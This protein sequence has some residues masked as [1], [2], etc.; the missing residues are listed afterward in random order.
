MP[1]L[2]LTPYRPSG[3]V[4]AMETPFSPAADR[5]KEAI[6]SVLKEHLPTGPCLG[7]EVGSATG[8]HGLY[9]LEH[10]SEL[11][12]VF[13]DQPQW[14]DHLCSVSDHPRAIGPYVYT[15][16]TDPLPRVYP[17]SDSHSSQALA[18]NFL[19]TS[20][21][22]H[23]MSWEEAQEFLKVGA[24][25]L[26]CGGLFFIYGPF[27]EGSRFT[28]DSNRAFDEKLKSENPRM[29]LRDRHM[30]KNLLESRGCSLVNA[31][32]MPANNFILLFKKD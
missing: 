9:F 15:A 13:C 2:E 4:E 8:Q 6:L 19:Y 20:N 22:L 16:G 28:S 29:G 32:P 14:Q 26:G 12:W 17:S 25:Y 18:V 1:C 23:I 31:I 27:N 10:L 11:R 21:T 3:I 7:V 24:D 5:N 30:V